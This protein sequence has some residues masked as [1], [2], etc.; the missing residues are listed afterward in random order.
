MEV[1]AIEFVIEMS[2]SL[3]FRLIPPLLCFL[4][5]QGALAADAE[6]E[7]VDERTALEISQQLTRFEENIANLEGEF[8]PYDASLLEALL[9]QGRYLTQIGQHQAAAA[10]YDRAL[11]ITRI[12]DGLLSEQQLPVLDELTA[13]HKAAGD[14][15]KADDREHLTWYLQSRLH[16]PGSVAHTQA[17]LD[18]GNW[19]LQVVQRNL[20]GRSTRANLEDMLILQESYTNA[21]DLIAIAQVTDSDTAVSAAQHFSLLLG[22]TRTDYMLAEYLIRTLPSAVD[23]YVPQYVSV[24][25]CETVQ[26]ANGVPTRVCRTERVDNPRYREAQMQKRLYEDRIDTTL[27]GVRSSIERM[28]AIVDANPQLQTTEGAS[29]QQTLDEAA[30]SYGQLQQEFRRSTLFW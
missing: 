9:D 17:L 10:T 23:R 24:Q 28:Q 5:A 22:K 30:G 2:K 14:W 8:G 3:F 15:Q 16:A 4:L 27:R 7:L 25:V 20:L 12:S 1:R 18:Y 11:S 29:A 19:K 26:G 21:V 13:A 6:A